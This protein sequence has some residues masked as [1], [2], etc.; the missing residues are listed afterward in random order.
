[1]SG[2]LACNIYRGKKERCVEVRLCVFH[3]YHHRERVGH[4]VYVTCQVLVA[5]GEGFC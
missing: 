1:M 2:L 3:T 5:H 4:P